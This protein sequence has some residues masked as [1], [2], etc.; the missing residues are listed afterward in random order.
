MAYTVT[1][2]TPTAGFNRAKFSLS[3]F[4]DYTSR[5]S[6]PLVN[7]EFSATR[8]YRYI[9]LLN[10]D[11]PVALIEF[12]HVISNIKLCLTK[13]VT[14]YEYVLVYDL[15]LVVGDFTSPIYAISLPSVLSNSLSRSKG[16]LSVPVPTYKTLSYIK[17]STSEAALLGSVMKYPDVG[18]KCSDQMCK[19]ICKYLGLSTTTV[20]CQ[21]F[22]MILYFNSITS[23]GYEFTLYNLYTK[24][25]V[26]N[27]QKV[28]LST[29]KI[30]TMSIMPSFIN[31][32]TLIV[33]GRYY[34]YNS[35]TAT[36]YDQE[37]YQDSLQ[38]MT[39]GVVTDYV[40]FSYKGYVLGYDINSKSLK[41]IQ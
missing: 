39:N 30:N 15:T 34:V 12:N 11:A 33:Q 18:Y 20:M 8:S 31:D 32:H 38:L 40:A 27:A 5:D 13:V 26:T 35:S 22:H 23:T 25:K 36:I 29:S 19:D 17:K 41:R 21:Y 9:L 10:N 14:K 4:S 37:R 2:I 6:V 16:I 3:P 1:Q 7:G 24:K 28:V